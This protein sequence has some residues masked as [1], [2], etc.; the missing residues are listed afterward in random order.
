VNPTPW[1]EKRERWARRYI[2]ADR[3]AVW[4]CALGVLV[5]GL[6][7]VIERESDFF[8]ASIGFSLLGL[9]FLRHLAGMMDEFTAMMKNRPRSTVHLTTWVR[10]RPWQTE[11]MC[12]CGAMVHMSRAKWCANEIDRG[13]GRFSIVCSCG[14]GYYKLRES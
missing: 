10:L 14:A 5:T 9:F 4:F 2:Y 12:H 6:A 7:S 3:F 11:M 8:W 1:S 13:G